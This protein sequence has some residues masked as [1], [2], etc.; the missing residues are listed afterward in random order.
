[1]WLSSGIEANTNRTAEFLYAWTLSQD[2]EG[3]DQRGGNKNHR[4][5]F[6]DVGRRELRF[7]RASG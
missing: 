5:V 1:M 3:D 2:Y 4:P 7:H 6:G